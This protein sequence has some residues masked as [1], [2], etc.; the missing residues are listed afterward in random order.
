M[1]VKLDLPIAVAS[2]SFSRNPLLREELGKKFTSI[3]YND[4]GKA[5]AGEEL[6]DF[7]QD[8][9]GAIIALE[10][11]TR[12]VLEALPGLKFIGKYGVGKDG[13]DQKAMKDLGVKLGWSGGHNKQSVAELVL[14]FM[15]GIAR[16]I[17][18]GMKNIHEE[19]WIV[20]GGFQLDGKTVGI[21]GC[22]HVGRTVINL[23]SPFGCKILGNDILDMDDYFKE[24]GVIKASKEEIYK[25]AD[26][27]TLH[28]PYSTTTHH[29]IST[30]ELEKMKKE[31]ILINTSRG[32][33]VDEQ[34][35]YKSL[36]S[37]SIGG[38][39][40]DVFEEEPCINGALLEL[41]NFFPTPHIGGSAKEAIINMGRAAIS[42]LFE[43][44]RDTNQ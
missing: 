29:L 14:C 3:R 28:I 11:I 12:D 8:R 7:L 22:G 43:I 31:T 36:Q 38:G 24:N 23:L 10:K 37:G 16:N 25:E 42:N 9:T 13:L 20:Q 4:A 44:M 40:A 39:A 27:I 6:I 26:F 32:G 18:V 41:S 15:L 17:F 5:L 19:K 35:L 21:I 30:Q 34:A 1:T 2:R 33:I